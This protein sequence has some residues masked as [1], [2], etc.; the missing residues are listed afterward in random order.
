M[1]PCSLVCNR[2]RNT[3]KPCGDGEQSWGS[4]RT[5]GPALWTEDAW[6]ELLPPVHPPVRSGVWRL[7]VPAS[8]G[9]FPGAV[10]LPAVA[11]MSAQLNGTEPLQSSPFLLPFPIRIVLE[12]VRT[13]ES[14]LGERTSQFS[15]NTTSLAWRQQ[16]EV[17][18]FED[19]DGPVPHVNPKSTSWVPSLAARSQSVTVLV[20]SPD[21]APFLATICEDGSVA[22]PDLAFC[23]CLK[24]S[25]QKPCWEILLGRSSVTPSLLWRAE[26]GRLSTVLCLQSF[27]HSLVANYGIWD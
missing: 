14:I 16:S 27:P 5:P 21:S 8:W 3:T 9:F 23:R 6:R 7:V 11:K 26:A 19:E 22:V 17:F 13:V 25:P 2:K 18:V 10:R 12:V 24:L 4:V 20:F 15:Y 1:V